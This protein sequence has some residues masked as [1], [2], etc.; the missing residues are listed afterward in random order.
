[1]VTRSQKSEIHCRDTKEGTRFRIW[2]PFIERYSTGP[3][4]EEAMKEWYGKY[5]ILSLY[6]LVQAKKKIFIPNCDRHIPEMSI[7]RLVGDYDRGQGNGEPGETVGVMW[8][9]EDY[10]V[11]PVL[12]AGS[13][14]RFLDDRIQVLGDLDEEDPEIRIERASRRGTSTLEPG[15]TPILLTSGWKVER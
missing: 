1:M 5:R 2:T 13:A 8:N 14:Y 12:R 7:G 9:S 3:L 15:S 6:T 11:H 10:T 4:T